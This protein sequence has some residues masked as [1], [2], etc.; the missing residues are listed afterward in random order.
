[1]VCKK[2]VISH[3]PLV[4]VHLYQIIPILVYILGCGTA[5]L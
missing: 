2:H 3:I 4:I 1:M 5:F